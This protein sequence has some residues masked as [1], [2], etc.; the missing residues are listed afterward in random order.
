M[1]CSGAHGW[2]AFGA[3]RQHAVSRESPVL[4]VGTIGARQ[5]PLEQRRALQHGLIEFTTLLPIAWRRME[6]NKDR[7][8]AAPP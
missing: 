7:G 1:Q 2:R 8:Q 5:E 6:T 3:L 4:D